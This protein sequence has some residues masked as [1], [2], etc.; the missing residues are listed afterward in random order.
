M[1]KPFPHT[2]RDWQQELVDRYRTPPIKVDFLLVAT[3]G[4][5]KTIAALKVAHDLFAENV[6]SRLVIV[7]HTDYLRKQWIDEASLAGIPLA[8]L[9]VNTWKEIVIPGGFLGVVLTYTQV[10]TKG[11]ADILRAWCYKERVGLIGDEIHHLGDDLTWGTACQT[12]FEPC[13]RRLLLSGT[14]FRSDDNQIPFID[15]PAGRARADFMY[16]YGR[17]VMDKEVVRPIVFPT[18]D[19]ELIWMDGWELKQHTFRDE[20]SDDE[21]RAMI[22]TAINPKGTWIRDVITAADRQLTTI[23]ET[24]HA[25]AGGLIIASD[26]TAADDLAKVV[27]EITGERAAVATMAVDDAKAVIERFKVST[28]KWLVAVKMVSE[29][30]DIRRL[31]VGVYATNVRTR[32]FFY[33]VLG[34]VLRWEK[35]IDQQTAYFYFPSDQ[36]LL[37]YMKEIMDEIAHRIKDGDSKWE[38]ERLPGGG[39][40]ARFYQ[41]VDAGP[42]IPSDT[43]Y[44]VYE[45]PAAVLAQARAAF[46]G[47]PGI[48]SLSD[49]ELALM[50]YRARGEEPPHRNSPPPVEQPL[51][52]ISEHRERLALRTQAQ[53]A[54]GKIAGLVVKRQLEPSLDIA[55][56]KINRAWLRKTGLDKEQMSNQEYR[57]KIDWLSELYQEIAGGNDNVWRRYAA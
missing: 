32:V 55:C 46:S 30:V 41:F 9:S 29:G 4:G 15:Y 52:H 34:R 7:C 50:F 2:L 10:A 12:A 48:R 20:V 47:I 25:N 44:Q 23:R 51:S 24:G 56:R 33:Q 8:E 31:R 18:W 37:R 45:F 53:K 49:A 43:I 35:G 42:A 22:L 54:V 19:G 11:N 57:E 16:G 36:L 39:V 28:T 17:A 1:L 26:T 5:G 27:Y 6:I 3:P 38:I 40:Q 14:P 13:Q 21:A